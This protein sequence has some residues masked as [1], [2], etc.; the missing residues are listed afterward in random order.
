MKTN[1]MITYSDAS[2]ITRCF[3]CDVAFLT[4]KETGRAL[5]RPDG[6]VHE[7]WGNWGWDDQEIFCPNG[8]SVVEAISGWNYV[9][10]IYGIA[11][12]GI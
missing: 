11:K 12:V 7:F 10:K 9:M 3:F 8:W 4:N 2:D 6:S 5:V 1:K